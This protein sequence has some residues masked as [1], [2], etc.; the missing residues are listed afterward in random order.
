ML[1]PNKETFISL[2][3]MKLCYNRYAQLYF[4][5]IPKIYFHRSDP[6]N[7]LTE[8]LN[9]EPICTSIIHRCIIYN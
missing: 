8:R 1:A 7:N 6:S 5:T 4:T 9:L 3:N 2:L